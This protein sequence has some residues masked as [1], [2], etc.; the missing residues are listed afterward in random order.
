M[1][2]PRV[3]VIFVFS[4]VG[5]QAAMAATKTIPI[6]F[7]TGSDSVAAAID[8]TEARKRL[9]VAAPA[10]AEACRWTFGGM[11]MTTIGYERSR[12]SWSPCN[13]TSS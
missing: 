6:V 13:P 4:D 10:G 11:V 12:R 1:G 7:A 9:K 3:A 5:L 8:P 2:S